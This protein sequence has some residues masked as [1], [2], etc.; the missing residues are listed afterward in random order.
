MERT[1]Y[2]MVRATSRL[3]R[4]NRANRPMSGAQACSNGSGSSARLMKRNP[5]Q[6]ATGTAKRGQSALS[7]R[8]ISP[9]D[10]APSSRPSS[11]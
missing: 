7:N 9:A 11:A 5:S 1:S 4:L 2:S 6:A 8:S 3:G 10:G